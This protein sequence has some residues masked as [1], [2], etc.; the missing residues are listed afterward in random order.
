[1]LFDT[2]CHLNF[3]A[4]VG[5]VD[6]TIKRAREA[7][8]NYIMVPGTDVKTSQKAVEVAQNYDNIY[9]A[10]GIHPHHIYRYLAN[11]HHELVYPVRGSGS[12]IEIPKLI[13]DDIQTIEKLLTHKKVLAIGEVGMDR[14][15]Y[16]KTKYQDYTIE[17]QFIDLQKEV[18]KEQIRLAIK[19]KKSLIFHNREAKKDFLEAISEFVEALSSKAVFHCCEPDPELLGFA[20]SHRFFIGV[21]GDIAYRED[22]Q[23]FIKK[24]PLDLLVL[25][26]DAPFLSP[27]RK[28]PN[29]PARISFIAGFIANILKMSEEDLAKVTTG[30]AK[31]LFN[32]K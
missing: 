30:N 19:Y 27:D 3:S 13:R 14:H 23:E 11:S 18:L 16:K 12:T 22:K 9:A 7:G 4:F 32:I 17:R 25:E 10:V 26:T 21:D 6:E 29:E 31:K 8:V 5:Q 24:V 28:F 1:M 2:H 15:I 20:R